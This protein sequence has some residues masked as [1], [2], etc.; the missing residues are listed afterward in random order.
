MGKEPIVKAREEQPW[1]TSVASWLW[2]VSRLAFG[3]T[4]VLFFST[5]S[6]KH[7]VFARFS[8]L[9]V[10]LAGMTYPMGVFV[11]LPIVAVVAGMCGRLIGKARHGSYC[12]RI[13]LPVVSL[14]LLILAR[15]WPAQVLSVSVLASL[16]I[17]LFL[18]AYVCTVGAMTERSVIIIFTILLLLQGIV[19]SAQFLTQRSVGLS[20][21]GEFDLHPE[22]KLV[23]VIDIGG[24]RWLRAYGLTAH[25]NLLGGYLVL[26]LLVCLGQVAQGRPKQRGISAIHVWL[27][28]IIGAAGVFCS[29]SRSAWLGLVVGLAYFVALERSHIRAVRH[30]LGNRRAMVVALIVCVVALTVLFVYRELLLTRLFRLDTPLESRS[31]RERFEEVAQAWGLICERPL[32]GVGSGYYLR[33]LWD[34]AGDRPPPG[35]RLIHNIPL[36]SFAE[37]GFLGPVMWLWMLLTPVVVSLRTSWRRLVGPSEAGWAAAFAA[38]TVFSMFDSYLYL[39]VTLWPTLCLGVLAGGWAKSHKKVGC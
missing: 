2:G 32:V 24:K 4:Y 30:R 3:L 39:P 33:A 11:L 38:A 1:R 31:I 13:T 5:P 20:W 17:G 18:F 23:S 7:G 19:G 22:G 27:A 35:F 37:L 16:A 9:S 10:S 29:F 15:A 26:W 14:G 8:L 36:L 28:I 21:L 34:R 12:W 25:P 6:W